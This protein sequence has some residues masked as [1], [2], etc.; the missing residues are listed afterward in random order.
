MSPPAIRLSALA[1][2][3]MTSL[4]TASLNTASLNTAAAAGLAAHN[5]ARATVA[6][7]ELHTHAAALSDDTFEGREAGSRGGRAAAGYI[8][9][10]LRAYGLRGAGDDATFVQSFN[11]GHHNL[12]AILPGSDPKLRDEYVVIGAHYDHVGYGNQQNSYGPYGYIHNG[13][14]DNASG[15]SALL[16][17]AQALSSLGPGALRRSVIFAFWDGEEKGLLGSKHWLSAPT[18][19]LAGIKAAINVDM[20]GR[21]RNDQLEV[22]GSRSGSGFRKLIS[23][24]NADGSMKLDF[25]WEIKEDSDHHS[26]Y[27]RGIPVV[28]F[29]TGKHGDY[30]RP[31]DDVEKL[32][33][34][35]IQR[36]ARLMVDVTMDLADTDDLPR[37]RE[38]SRR[39]TL[40]ERGR[41]A[42]ELP[43]LVNPAGR[44]G[45]KW[46][47][48]VEGEEG[49]VV[50]SVQAGSAAARA[51]IRAGDRL[52][53]FAGQT[54][55]G[56]REF[57]RAVSR[58]AQPAVIRAIPAGGNDLKDY[59]VTLDGGPIRFGV[60]WVEDDAEPAAVFVKAVHPH[61]PAAEAGLVS[62][63][64]IYG[65][66]G[67]PFVGGEQFEKLLDGASGET[68]LAVERSGIVST[69]KLDVP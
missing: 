26:F 21:L 66:N 62:G 65:I 52:L 55:D 4:G 48:R 46:K 59:T 19:P 38:V 68:A 2:L 34:D 15:V 69:L 29:H 32:N 35:G 40:N 58:Q 39:E 20:V 47:S 31:S 67:R 9:E 51:G 6:V 44:F 8:A 12:L 56:D 64:R 7:S 13:A 61:S 24:R 22:V 3:V 57:Q 5:A 1:V 41:S 50:T 27:R 54:I 18:V 63:D 33:L 36:V 42:F 30:H 10:K 14:D 16:E 45:I 43:M 49:I 60:T 53:T 28:M 17:T 25:P 11:R 23:Q 37:F